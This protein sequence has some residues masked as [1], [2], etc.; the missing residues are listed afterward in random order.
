MLIYTQNMQNSKYKKNNRKLPVILETEEVARLLSIPNKRFMSGLRNKAMLRLMLS[1]GLRVSEV[2]NLRPS[3]IN[4]TLRKLRIVNGKGGVD[5][6]IIIPEFIIDLLKEWK[7][8]KPNGVGYFFTTYSGNKL[9]RVY[10]YNMVRNYTKRAAINKNIS[11][12]TLRHCFGTTF[13]KQT[14]DIET[15]RKILGHSHI[16]TTQI[17]VNLANIDVERAMNGFKDY[18]EV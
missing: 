14:R 3:D 15:L 16:S 1:M 10:I 5:R 17:Y 18:T 6:D 4:L 7:D 8:R 13:Y 12:H 9:S 11:P 2:V